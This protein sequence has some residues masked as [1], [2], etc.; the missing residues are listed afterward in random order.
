MDTRTGKYDPKMCVKLSLEAIIDG[1]LSKNRSELVYWYSSP[2]FVRPRLVWMMFQLNCIDRSRQLMQ[3]IRKR[4]TPP[5][6]SLWI[7]PAALRSSLRVALMQQG[8]TVLQTLKDHKQ[9]VGYMIILIPFDFT[10]LG[11]DIF[12]R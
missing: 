8:V 5:P 1:L 6:K 2:S 11:D 7:A 12:A 3:H 10:Y 9:E 4:C